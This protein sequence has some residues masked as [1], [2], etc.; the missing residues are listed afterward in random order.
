MES[1]HEYIKPKY[2][3]QIS[4][5]CLFVILKFQGEI[6]K[7]APKTNTIVARGARRLTLRN[8]HYCFFRPSSTSPNQIHD[9]WY[10]PLCPFIGV[11]SKSGARP[12]FHLNSSPFFSFLAFHLFWFLQPLLPSEL[13]LLL[14]IPSDSLWLTRG[15]WSFS[16]P[17]VFQNLRCFSNW[18]QFDFFH[19][20][21][22][23]VQ[24]RLNRGNLNSI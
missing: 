1:W 10:V 3:V 16:T 4:V 2:L 7:M 8:L 22:G 18:N 19:H 6:K 20:Q 12:S 11:S 9:V 14:A 15:C 24:S 23:I 21:V 13:S 17:T 5:H